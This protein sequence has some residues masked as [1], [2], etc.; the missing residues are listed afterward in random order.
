MIITLMTIDFM[1]YVILRIMI[2]LIFNYDAISITAFD[3][4]R[5]YATWFSLIILSKSWIEV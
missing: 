4:C 5:I 2:K 1:F 3:I